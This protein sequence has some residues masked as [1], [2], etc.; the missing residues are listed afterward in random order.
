MHIGR[1]AMKK[2]GAS[3]EKRPR[4][5]MSAAFWPTSYPNDFPFIAAIEARYDVIGFDHALASPHTHDSLEIG[6]CHSGKGFFQI[7]NSTVDYHPGDT[8][9]IPA[10]TPH[11]AYYAKPSVWTWMNC[12]PVRLFIQDPANA[13]LSDPST[14]IGPDFIS[15][16]PQEE[17]PA[18]ESAMSLLI[19]EAKGGARYF[20]QSVQG[21]VLYVLAYLRRHQE[22]AAKSNQAYR[23]SHKGDFE[24]IRPA[25]DIMHSRYSDKLS[26]DELGASV[27]MSVTNFRRIFRT[28]TGK[29][30]HDYLSGYRIAM[31]ARQL[32]NTNK[33]TDMIASNCGF[34]DMSAF[35]RAFRIITG[36]TPAAWRAGTGGGA[37]S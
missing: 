3:A 9:I 32:R 29:S 31:A 14:L 35:R 12:D 28:V 21:L 30:P 17:H 36:T 7:A 10:M 37:S 27:S 2:P 26:I 16:Y 5:V 22:K 25:L 20:R 24:R 19:N 11:I 1:P 33:K 4:N 15:V 8:V 34:D 6:Y 23:P 13:S 18:L